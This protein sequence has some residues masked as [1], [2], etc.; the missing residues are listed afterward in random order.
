MDVCMYICTVQDPVTK[1][2]NALVQKFIVPIRKIKHQL[3]QN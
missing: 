1:H 2:Q 3:E